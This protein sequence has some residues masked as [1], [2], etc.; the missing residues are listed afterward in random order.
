MSNDLK[1]FFENN[2]GALIHKWDHYFDI[3]HRHFER[4]RNQEIVILEIGVYQGGSLQM[5]KNYF[6]S[7]A[8]IFGIDINPNC[9]NLEEENIKIFIGSQADREFLREVK[10]KIPP[11]DILIDD[12]GHRMDEQIVTFEEIFEKVKPDGVYLCEDL[13]TSYSLTYGGGHQRRNTFIEYSKHFIDRI[14]AFHSEQ[15]SLKIDS[16]TTSV[17]SVHFYDSV[18][19]IEKQKRG[20]PFHKKTGVTRYENE[21]IER[22]SGLPAIKFFILKVI[23]SALRYFNLPSYKWGRARKK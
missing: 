21:P 8:K 15:G 6:G 2:Q 11:I 18:L 19:V 10:N 14:N 22:L 17:N 7:K 9:K 23:N 16:F 3:Y 12:G 4:F 5:W 13:H 20:K 1:V